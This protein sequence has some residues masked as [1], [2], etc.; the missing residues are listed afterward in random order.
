MVFF[1]IFWKDLDVQDMINA[2]AKALG[3][4]HFIESPARAP[5][6]PASRVGKEDKIAELG[7]QHW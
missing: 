4:H 5:F 2:M 1:A 6:R 3:L 7:A